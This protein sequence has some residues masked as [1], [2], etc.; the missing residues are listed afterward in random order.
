MAN[1][2]NHSN[3]YMD[4]LFQ[5]DSPGG[6]SSLN[7]RVAHTPEREEAF[8]PN[9]TTSDSRGQLSRRLGPVPAVGVGSRMSK[10]IMNKDTSSKAGKRKTPRNT[11]KKKGN[12]S[13]LKGMNS[14]KRNVTHINALPRKK[15]C[16]E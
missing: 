6:S 7:H 9:R 3:L 8:L 5:E 4:R 13:P 12:N 10:R 2:D 11:T 14:R 1:D 15:R 16:E